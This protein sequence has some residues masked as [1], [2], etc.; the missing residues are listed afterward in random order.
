MGCE[1]MESEVPK[2]RQNKTKATQCFFPL[3]LINHF[4][5]LNLNIWLPWQVTEEEKS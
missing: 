3:L 1:V 2:T 5:S 4:L